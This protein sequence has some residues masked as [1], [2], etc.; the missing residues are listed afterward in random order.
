SDGTMDDA[1]RDW[2]VAQIEP[3]VG[4]QEEARALGYAK[5]QAVRLSR[6][7]TALM[8]ALALGLILVL[9]WWEARSQTASLASTTG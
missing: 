8:V 5:S 9:A 2:Y 6:I 4:L 1:V 7:A 3:L